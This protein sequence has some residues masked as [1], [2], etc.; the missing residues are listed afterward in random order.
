MSVR[1]TT[2][3]HEILAR[4]EFAPTLTAAELAKD[5]G[6]RPSTVAHRIRI[7]EEQGLIARKAL[8][9][10]WGLGMTPIAIFFS[11]RSG[12]RGQQAKV[13]RAIVN[14]P[15]VTWCG[16]LSGEFHC[17]VTLLVRKIDE[18]AVFLDRIGKDGDALIAEKTFAPRRRVTFFSRRYL[19]QRYA[20]TRSITFEPVEPV[21]ELDE[22]DK[23]LL[24]RLAVKTYGSLR[25]IAQDLKAAPSTIERR[26]KQLEEHQVIAGWINQ[27]D[28]TRLGMTS[29]RLLITTERFNTGLRAQLERFA[30]KNSGVVLLVEAMGT[31]DFEL[32][33]E[34]SDLKTLVGT[35]QDLYEVG[36]G[37][38]RS[39]HTLQEIEDLK[40]NLY[41]M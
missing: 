27:I 23:Q 39:I 1:L 19:D 26:I 14:H 7:F 16:L 34:V 9:N 11:L 12:I 5:L 20:Q 8:I 21:V 36:A 40:F 6:M 41:P 37:E 10:P 17:G 29:Y 15:N 13:L 35:V 3:D 24:Q 22:L 2:H 28:S 30:Q 32:E 33:L 31:F 25:I 4:I 18:L 38:I